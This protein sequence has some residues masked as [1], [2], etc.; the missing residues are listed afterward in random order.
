MLARFLPRTLPGTP[1]TKQ[2]LPA[3]GSGS[4]FGRSGSKKIYQGEMMSN[5]L[6]MMLSFFGAFTTGIMIALELKLVKIRPLRAE[7][8]DQI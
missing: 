3:I 7:D 1:G 8:N 6:E 2:Q 5:E 4:K